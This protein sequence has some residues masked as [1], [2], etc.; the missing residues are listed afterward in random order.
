MHLLLKNG[1]GL[2]TVGGKPVG[3]ERWGLFVPQLPKGG[4]E[5]PPSADPILAK[6]EERLVRGKD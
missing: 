5:Q 1:K 3:K 4:G 6:E 2:P